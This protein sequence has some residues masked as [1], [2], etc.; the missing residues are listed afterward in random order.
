MTAYVITPRRRCY[1]FVEIC[2][3]GRRRLV[4]KFSSEDQ[5]VMGLRMLNRGAPT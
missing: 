4:E 5:A 1:W 3:D 2:D